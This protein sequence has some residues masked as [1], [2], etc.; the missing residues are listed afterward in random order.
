MLHAAGARS[1]ALA[2]VTP[3]PHNCAPRRR[4][5]PAHTRFGRTASPIDG[6]RKA[7]G[8]TKMPLCARNMARELQAPGGGQEREGSPAKAHRRHM[9]TCKCFSKH[10]NPLRKMPLTTS[11]L[12]RFMAFHTVPYVPSPSCLTT[13]YLHMASSCNCCYCL[14]CPRWQGQPGTA[15]RRAE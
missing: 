4:R 3:W 5:A 14:C 6:H 10:L 13:L 8:S 15:H 7:M 9:A 1:R 2:T 11:L 12:C